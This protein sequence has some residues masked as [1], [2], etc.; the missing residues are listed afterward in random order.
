[1]QF[2]LNCRYYSEHNDLLSLLDPAAVEV[3]TNPVIIIST[4][5]GAN[6]ALDV[7]SQIR[8]HGIELE[9]RVE[10]IYSTNNIHLL[11][12]VTNCIA[13]VKVN[14]LFVT[15]ALTKTNNN[16]EE[17]LNRTISLKV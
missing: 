17:V 13:A 7:V 3:G 11:Q 6:F 5:A 9:K 1:M 16:F 8:K 4:G 14:N 2:D 10:I 15:A 12:Y